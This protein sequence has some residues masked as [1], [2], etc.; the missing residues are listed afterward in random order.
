MRASVKG[1][2]TILLVCRSSFFVFL[3]TILFSTYSFSQSGDDTLLIVHDRV[4]KKSEFLYHWQKTGQEITNKNISE[5]LKSY[6]NFQLKLADARERGFQ[7]NIAFIN[8]LKEYRLLLAAPYLTDKEK[9]EN[10][11]NETSESINV[12]DKKIE[13]SFVEK[14]KKYWSF[15]ENMSA[16]EAICKVADERVYNGSWIAPA[17]QAFGET[18]IV[19]DGK[20]IDQNAFIDF[21]QD[22]KATNKDLSVRDYIISLYKQFVAKRLMIYENYKLEEKYPDF[23]YQYQEYRD[24]M[25]LQ[26]I[27]KAR[28]WDKAPSDTAG[29]RKFFDENREKYKSEKCISEPG[30]ISLDEVSDIVLN[31]YQTYLMD[32]WIEELKRKYKV[33]INED[34]LSSVF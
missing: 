11:K 5:F 30:Y 31:D 12:I 8:E 2:E 27:T 32:N 6:I 17:D 3:I 1:S 22:F 24:A 10:T 7:R 34:V 18:L 29:I 23:R 28:I 16:L 19:I 13:D 14:L 9:E 25:L 26:Q 15:K 4:I 21:M 20:S 33:Q